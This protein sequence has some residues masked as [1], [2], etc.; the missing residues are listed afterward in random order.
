MVR[1]A[2][3]AMGGDQAPATEVE[4]AL[5]AVNELPGDFVV[6]LVGPGA[7]LEAELARH[8]D[9]DRRRIQVVDAPEV[10]GMA[11]KPLEAVRKKRK[12]SIVVGL[13]LQKAGQSDAFV[14]AG[15]TG[16]MLAASTIVLGLHPGVERA[17][18]GTLLPTVEGPVLL[19]DAGANVDCSPRELTGFAYLGAIYMRDVVA[20]ENPRVALLNIGEEDEKGTAQVREAHRL[21]KT[22]P[23]LNYVGNI[24]GR[25]IL[26]GHQ[27]L[28]RLDVVVADGFVG[29]IVL[30]FYESVLSLVRHLAELEGLWDRPETRNA[31]RMLDYSQYGGAPLLGVK[32]YS[33]ICHGSSNAYAIMNAIRVAV[34]TVECG[35]NAHIATH[36]AEPVK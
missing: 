36:F 27:R 2:L 22:A 19:L 33:I 14:S 13:G 20:R 10:I 25:D 11:E 31:F 15:N 17:T 23:G 5:R 29:N 30:K 4:G 34:T 6:Q 32:G 35:L 7:R 21:L 24:E 12:S 3:D 9:V 8:S 26:G 1:I 16:A 28:G 18:V